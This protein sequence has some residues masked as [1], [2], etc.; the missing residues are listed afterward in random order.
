MPAV[1]DLPT[2]LTQLAEPAPP[3][4]LSVSLRLDPATL[5]AVDALALRLNRAT[6]G[7]MLAYLVR[8]GLSAT[9]A[10]LTEAAATDAGGGRG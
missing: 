10:Q 8:A 5:A 1:S 2:D 3:P 4:R 6:R 7:A 9:D